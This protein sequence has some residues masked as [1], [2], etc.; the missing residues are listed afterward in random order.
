M[1]F[2]FLL[3]HIMAEHKNQHY[4]SQFYLKN[5]SSDRKTIGTLI[6]SSNKFI[7]NAPIKNQC[8]K[9]NFYQDKNYEI[10]LSELEADTSVIFDKI[11]NKEDLSSKE[12]F[13]ARAFMLLQETRTKHSADLFQEGFKQVTAP[14]GTG[15]GYVDYSYLPAGKTGTAQSFLDTDGDGIIDTATT[16]STF[17][18][19]VPFDDPEV[20]FTVISPDVAPEEVSYSNM[21]RVNTRISQKVSKKYF[22]IYG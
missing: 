14:G 11:M 5:F 3:N 8:S 1:A 17:A 2:L 9:D 16:T 18:A 15:Y 13:I 21:S 7:E 19:Y 22:E 4:V 12:K 20:V 6:L 10:A